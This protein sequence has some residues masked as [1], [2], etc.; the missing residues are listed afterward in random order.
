M[1]DPSKA[2]TGLPTSLRAELLKSYREIAANYSERRWEPSELNGGKF[3]EVVYSIIRG[4]LSGSFPTKSSKPSDMVKAC[5]ALESEPADPARAGDHSLRILIPRVLLPLY[6]I[7]NNRGVGHVGGDVD[8]NFLDA[9]AVYGMASWVL[10]EL[11]RIFHS[12]S[13]SEAQE[14]VDALAEHKHPLIW[15][16]EGVERVLDPSMKAADQTLLLLHAKRSWISEEGLLNSVEYSNAT[17]FRQKVLKPLH[18]TRLIE[19]D[20]KGHRAHIS[21]K[22]SQ[23]VE[24][25]ILKT[26]S[27]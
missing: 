9:T 2:L 16:I 14:V 18:D 6:D 4:V 22:G 1:I 3:C 19:H 15:T 21:P 26:R 27:K 12:V 10:A 7:R 23:E 25:R 17:V 20:K 8:P 24:T 13:T 11:V 5:R